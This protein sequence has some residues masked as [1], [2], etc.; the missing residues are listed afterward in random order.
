MEHREWMFRA[1]TPYTPC[2]DEPKKNRYQNDNNLLPGLYTT[3]HLI[4]NW[5]FNILC[6]VEHSR[7]TLQVSPDAE[8]DYIHAMYVVDYKQK[9]NYIVAQQPLRNTLSDFWLMVIQNQVEV[10]INLNE[11]NCTN[12]VKLQQLT[13][14]NFYS[15]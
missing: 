13:P 9:E 15:N 12:S 14:Y 5:Q 3:P 1:L 10:I 7:V 4:L 2:S 6:L 11:L 8:S